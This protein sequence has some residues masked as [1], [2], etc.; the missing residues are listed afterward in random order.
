MLVSFF[1]VKLCILV[2]FQLTEIF[3]L[4][5]MIYTADAACYY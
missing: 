1:F 4:M 2:Y 5:Q 3:P